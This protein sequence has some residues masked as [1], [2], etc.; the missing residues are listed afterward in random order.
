MFKAA[1]RRS[2]TWE[3]LQVALRSE[4][5]ELAPRGGGL[6]LRSLTDQSDICKASE[7]GYGYSSLIKRFQAGFPVSDGHAPLISRF[8]GVAVG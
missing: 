2:T 6:V 7:L 4:D 5:L 1:L 8:R 3:D